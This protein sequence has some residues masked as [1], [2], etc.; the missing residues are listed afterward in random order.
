MTPDNASVT[1]TISRRPICNSGS[2]ES[3][4]ISEPEEQA[5]MPPTASRPKLVTFTSRTSSAKP[6]R[7]SRSPA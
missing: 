4:S 5:T 2:G 3:I 6:N 7:M 1:G